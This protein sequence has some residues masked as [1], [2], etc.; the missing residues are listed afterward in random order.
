MKRWDYREV[1]EE[2][3]K[4]NTIK[5]YYYFFRYQS[6]EKKSVFVSHENVILTIV[7]SVNPIESFIDQN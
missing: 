3:K 1:S 7:N 5:F 4:N 6:E 2:E